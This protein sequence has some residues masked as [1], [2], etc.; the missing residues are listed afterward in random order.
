MGIASIIISACIL[1]LIKEP[2]RGRY[3]TPE[4]K[5]KLLLL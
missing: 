5:T 3:A 4:E 2:E 1:F